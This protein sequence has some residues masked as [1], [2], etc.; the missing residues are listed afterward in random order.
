M[1][2]PCR[3]AHSPYTVA[4][5][6]MKTCYGFLILLLLPNLLLPISS[7]KSDE[8]CISQGGRFPPFSAEGKPPK[9][10]GKGSK[11]LTL[12]RV[13]RRKTCCD[14]SQTHP[15]LLSIRRLASS[16]EASQECLQLWELLECSICDPRIGVQKGPPLI[17]ASFCD[18]VY[19]ACTD[20]YFSMDAKA[21]V[22]APCGVN[23]FVCGRAAE[24]VSNGTELCKA[25][26]FTIKLIDFGTEETSCYGGKASLDSIANSWRKSEVSKRASKGE[27]LKDFEQWVEEMPFWERVSWAVGGMVL[28]AGL[29][30]ASKRRTRNQ[31]QKLA[32][33]QRTV[34]KL[35]GNNQNSP[36]NQGNRKG[37]RR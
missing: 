18:R 33:I 31:R 17:C 20:A 19:Q 24:W 37:V 10:V 2:F 29:L 15:A 30:F 5:R 3:L 1:D 27:V 8:V 12:C 26:G 28:T 32:A 4:C 11:D 16:G 35:E 21:Q 6:D 9:R 23:D 25:A 36:T 34:R 13:F 22:L 7:A 14:V